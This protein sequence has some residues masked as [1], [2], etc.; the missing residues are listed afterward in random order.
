[1]RFTSKTTLADMQAIRDALL[2]QMTDPGKLPIR[3][4][5]DGKLCRG[6]PVEFS[7]RTTR[8][9]I[10]ANIAERIYS[11]RIPN[12]PLSLRIECQ[13]YKDFPVWEWTA[14]FENVGEENSPVIS[15]FMGIDAVLLG[16]DEVILYHNNGDYCS[17]DGLE[18]TECVLEE[19][20][21]FTAASS[22]GHSCDHAWPYYRIVTGDIAYNI[23]IGWPGS[24]QAWFEKASCGVH[25]EAKQEYTNFYL[26]P[27]ETA[28]SPRM[29]V[30]ALR[31][32]S[33]R[34][35]NMWRRWYFAHCLNRSEGNPLGTKVC[36]SHSGGGDEHTLADE[37]NQIDAI[38]A[39]LERGEKPDIWWIDAGWYPCTN[40]D[41][42][43]GWTRTGDW[44]PD[45]EKFPNGLAPI[46]R[47]CEENGIQPLLWFM[48]E[49]IHPD[50][51][52]KENP[53]EF[54]V[55]LK[56]S[57]GDPWLDRIGLLDLGNPD[58][59]QWLTE[60]I[61]SIMTD[62]HFKIYRQ[63]FWPG[64]FPMAWWR[65][66]DGE[67][68][69][70]GISENLHIQGYLRFWD[71]L[72]MDIPDLW[73]DSCAGGGRRNDIEAM[74]RGVAL[75]ATDYGYGEHPVK[76]AFQKTWFEWTPYFRSAPQSWDDED[77]CYD[78]DKPPVHPF[79]SY[80]GHCSF[81]PVSAF[82][83]DAHAD[84]TVFRVASDW[85][86]LLKRAAP[87]TL[88]SDFFC[89][90]PV[91]KSSEDYFSIQFYKEDEDAG[92]IQVIRNTRCEENSIT[93]FPKAFES[94]KIYEFDAPETG[95]NFTVSGDEINEKG[96]T[97]RIPKRSGIFWFYKA[98]Q[99]Q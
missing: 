42:L 93:V 34:A 20:N 39:Y 52:P 35:V 43:K 84:E 1:M 74:R 2:D 90:T 21:I 41:G 44:R 48:P 16:T 18:T 12:T 57:V 45:P 49:F 50:H 69:R 13:E 23:A 56:N 87:Y 30:M 73:I 75:H 70:T 22:E 15:D 19:G 32:D 51:W 58:C 72:L 68:N 31:G 85:H 65:E 94:G 33:D 98:V 81:G 59:R 54:F 61:K 77:G 71:D 95:E 83:A 29:V 91:R 88:N 38:S 7:P 64:P 14:Y 63:D 67:E 6:I 79:D 92:V 3:Y 40:P 46:G 86:K 80:A 97:V 37:Q 96:L 8:R 25:V 99:K 11:C 60:R 53:E 27:G 78:Q 5:L 9:I 26:K 24:W 89:L 66:M 76:Q 17:H 4:R 28:R 82:P 10:D 36:F 62:G 55:G 47:L